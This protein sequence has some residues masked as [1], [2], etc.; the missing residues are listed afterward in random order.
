M[1]EGMVKSL[2]SGSDDSRAAVENHPRAMLV[3]VWFLLPTA[4]V[5]ARAV[6]FS[7]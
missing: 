6:T 3:R 1:A 4:R 2:R 5:R 7:Y